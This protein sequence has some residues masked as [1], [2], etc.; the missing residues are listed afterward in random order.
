MIQLMRVDGRLIHGMVAVTW[1]G[2]Y[3]PTVLVVVNDEAAN[4]DLL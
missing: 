2:V 4:N 3:K 1:C